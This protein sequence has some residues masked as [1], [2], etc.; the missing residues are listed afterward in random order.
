M[1]HHETSIEC[2]ALGL[3]IAVQLVYSLTGLD[4]TNQVNMLLFVCNTA[5]EAKP[6]KLVTSHTV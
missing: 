1:T 6:V 2:L 4:S 5:T 3:S